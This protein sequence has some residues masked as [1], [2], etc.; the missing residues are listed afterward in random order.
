MSQPRPDP[1]A[2]LARVQGGGGAAA[3]RQAEGLLR[4]RG[5]RRQDLRDARGRARAAKA[6]GRRRRRR[7]RRD[8][9]PRRDRGAP[10]TAS[11]SCRRARVEYRGVTLREF[12]LDAAL[13]RRPALVARRRARAHQRAGLAP[14]QALAGRRWS[15]ST[16]GIDV[17][18]TLNVQHVESLNDVV[19][20]DHRRGR[21]RDR[22][23]L[24]ARAGRRGR[25]DRSAARRP[26]RAPPRGQGLRARPGRGGGRGTSSARAT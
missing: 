16:P 6:D 18:T 12:D 2:L 22:A 8:P 20:E 4:R 15:C 24:G 21:A 17:Y 13:A 7:L 19:G 5:R 25:A 23:R 9:R 3:P 14:R 1:D 26:A 11:R 10:A